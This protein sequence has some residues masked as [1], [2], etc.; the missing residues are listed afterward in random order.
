[1]NAFLTGSH[2]YGKVRPN[3]DI[4][5]VVRVDEETATKLRRL[6]DSKETVRFGSLNLI[7]CTTDDEY[8]M[9]RMGTSQLISMANNTRLRY[10]KVEAK[11]TFDYLRDL[12]GLEDKIQSGGG[13]A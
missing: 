3:S 2:V 12:L 4:D 5:L 8:A 9:W 6:S 10:D 1:M 13:Q 11:E 7:L